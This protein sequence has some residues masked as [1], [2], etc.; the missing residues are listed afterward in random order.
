MCHAPRVSDEGFPPLLQLVDKFLAFEFARLLDD[1]ADKGVP[2][3]WGAT[4]LLQ[5]LENSVVI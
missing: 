1:V 5:V 2:D 3:V 4:D